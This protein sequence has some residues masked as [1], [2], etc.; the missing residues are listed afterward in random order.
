[1]QTYMGF[2]CYRTI[3]MR[4]NSVLKKLDNLHYWDG[5]HRS[6]KL[7]IMMQ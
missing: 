3:Q 1:M 6:L 2:K 5:L 7:C 4:K